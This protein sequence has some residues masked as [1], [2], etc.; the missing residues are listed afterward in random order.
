MKGQPGLPAGS[1]AMGRP[2]PSSA[3]TCVCPVRATEPGCACWGLSQSS[4]RSC[5]CLETSSALSASHPSLCLQPLQL[6][7]SHKT[8]KKQFAKCFQGTFASDSFSTACRTC[9]SDNTQL[10]T[11]SQTHNAPRHFHE[12]S[13]PGCFTS[14]L[15]NVVNLAFLLFFF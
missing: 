13:C 12:G 5:R 1:G 15:Q 14:H 6:L 8:G 7:H 4:A 2:L 10:L 11:S 3:R 9:M